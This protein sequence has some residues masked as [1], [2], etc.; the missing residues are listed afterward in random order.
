MN[1]Y[2]EKCLR[3]CSEIEDCKET[4]KFENQILTG[5]SGKKLCTALQL[6]TKELVNKNNIYLEIGVF[7]GLTLLS[8]ASY[9]KKSTCVG[10][11]NFSLFNKDGN[12]KKIVEDRINKLNIKN[13][14]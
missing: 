8:N 14:I 2:I 13:V 10:I 11:D 7:H 1:K 3:I 9:N 5:Y 6:F 4:I 12:N